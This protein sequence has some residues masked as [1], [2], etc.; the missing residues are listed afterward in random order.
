[1]IRGVSMRRDMDLIRALL[2]KIESMD[3]VPSGTT[4]ALRASAPELKIP[5]Y[6]EDQVDYHLEYLIDSKLVEGSCSVD[7]FFHICK[8]TRTGHDLSDSI[9]D[10]EIW[11]K[12]KDSARKAGGFTIELLG[13]PAKGL[14][15]TQIEKRTGVKL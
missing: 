6:T 3:I 12:T 8:L 1:M 9:R 10:P 11:R 14:I 5:G 2:L 15:R 13:E 7:R 4:P